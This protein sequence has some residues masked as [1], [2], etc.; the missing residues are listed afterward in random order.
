MGG[1]FSRALLF[2]LLAISIFAY[3]LFFGSGYRAM[4]PS[5]YEL[6]TGLLLFHPTTA[7]DAAQAIESEGYLSLAAQHRLL[8][9]LGSE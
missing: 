5:A 1:A 2:G 7:L 4:H 3:W 9:R 6:T 8:D